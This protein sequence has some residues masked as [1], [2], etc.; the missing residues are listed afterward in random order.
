MKTNENKETMENT[1]I[2]FTMIQPGIM[3]KIFGDVKKSINQVL[4]DI[5]SELVEYDEVDLIDLHQMEMP[6]ASTP[7]YAIS[8]AAWEHLKKKWEMNLKGGEI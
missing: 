7:H 6:H 8:V 2:S 5:E 3:D 4:D 1:P